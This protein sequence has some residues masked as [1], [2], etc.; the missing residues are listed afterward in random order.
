MWGGGMYDTVGWNKCVVGDL[1]EGF[2][3]PSPNKNKAQ[4]ECLE[5]YFKER[6][7]HTKRGPLRC[8]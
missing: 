6:M 3:T 8:L 7:F 1:G 2:P 5:I 4:V